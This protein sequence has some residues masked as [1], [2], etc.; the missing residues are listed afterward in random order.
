MQSRCLYVGEPVLMV[1]GQVL[2]IKRLAPGSHLSG[3]DLSNG[4]RHPREG[5]NYIA[6]GCYPG[7]FC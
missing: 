3:V 5:Y 7:H 2:S 4:F 6:W 1:H